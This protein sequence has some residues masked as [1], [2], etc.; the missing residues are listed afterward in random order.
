MQTK[1]KTIVPLSLGALLRP[2]TLGRPSDSSTHLTF[3]HAS[4]KK[5]RPQ[6]SHK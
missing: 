2:A 1:I 3:S 5:K 6:A 4:P